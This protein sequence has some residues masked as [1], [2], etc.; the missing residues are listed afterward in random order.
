MN[1]DRSW[2]RIMATDARFT[3]FLRK[4]PDLR[5]EL[6]AAYERGPK[7]APFNEAKSAED[8]SHFGWRYFGLGQPNGYNAPRTKQLREL[9]DWLGWAYKLL[10]ND[11]DNFYGELSTAWIAGPV[12]IKEISRVTNEL[13]NA[14]VGLGKLV[15]AAQRAAQGKP[16]RRGRP[17]GPSKL[18]PAQVIIGLAAVYR[19]ST[20]LRPT[21][22]KV[23]TTFAQN[24]L[25]TLWRHDIKYN[26]LREAIKG[27]KQVADKYAAAN[28]EW[29][30]PF[31]RE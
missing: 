28:P 27:A 17:R 21:A 24:C 6:H 10:K 4:I 8:L 5:R 30:S 13:N 16:S 23:F 29:L 14:I 26:S 1:S 20:G 18:P 12:P 22:S 2:P 11:I 3:V 9:A 19:R 25:S 15:L 7:L 31:A